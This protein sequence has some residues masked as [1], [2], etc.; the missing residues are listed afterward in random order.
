MTKEEARE[1]LNKW[2]EH[3]MKYSPRMNMP[4]VDEVVGGNLE[5]KG[6]TSIDK[7]VHEVTQYTFKGLIKLAYEL[8]DI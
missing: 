4:I 2:V 7:G 1:M 6:S 5:Y 8:K 3:K